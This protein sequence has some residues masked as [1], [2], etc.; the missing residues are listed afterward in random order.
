MG[1]F[2]KF[3]AT[4]SGCAQIDG[5]NFW[6]LKDVS[7]TVHDPGDGRIIGVGDLI[8]YAHVGW[9]GVGCCDNGTPGD[10]GEFGSISYFW[11]INFPSQDYNMPAT[12]S[13]IFVENVY[14]SLCPGAVVDVQVFW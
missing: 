4:G 9:F 10:P 6:Q 12:F 8:R 2:D 1:E 5:G 13:G 14:W 7:A 11:W 3:G